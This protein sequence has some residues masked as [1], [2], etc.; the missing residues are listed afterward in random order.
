MSVA[1]AGEY[2]SFGELAAVSYF[3]GKQQPVP[4]ADFEH[5]FGAVKTGKTAFGIL[6][7]ENS[8]AGSI[9]KNYDLLLHNGL[10]IIG[11]VLLRVSH[12]LLTN[13]GVGRRRIRTVY[14]H[15]QALDQCR[16]YLKRFGKVKT[17]PTS[18]TAAAV[19][20][21]KNEKLSGAAAIASMQ[22]A[23][24]YDMHV[25]A[26][27]IEDNHQNTTRFLILS[28]KPYRD[29][30]LPSGKMKTSVV[31]STKNMPGALFRSLSVFALR[32]INL[33]KIESRPMPGKHF[34]YLFYLDFEGNATDEIQTNAIHNLN[35]ITRFYRLLGSYPKGVMVNPTYRPKRRG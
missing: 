23:I 28:K 12:C 18:N 17:V 6:P 3:G 30:K 22:A 24:D 27:G 31:F 21:I 2:G 35:E 4:V 7:I 14:S 29:K 10:Y 19:L 11:E 5:I 34:E 33:L 20:K 8:Q 15:P 1:F 32:D 26:M 16:N 9:H 13:P 25:C